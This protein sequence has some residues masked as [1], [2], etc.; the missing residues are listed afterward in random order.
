MSS[1][2]TERS[3]ANCSDQ[4]PGVQ[5][6]LQMLLRYRLSV[7]ALALLIAL[8]PIWLFW[9]CFALF[10]MAMEA[11][12]NFGQGAHGEIYLLPILFYLALMVTGCLALVVCAD[13]KLAISNKSIRFP[14]QFLF[15]LKF[16]LDRPWS[17]L[18]SL[19]FESIDCSFVQPSQP[20]ILPISA[21][22]SR[23]A[24]KIVL[25]FADGAAVTLAVKGLS[26][27]H[28][29]EFILAVQSFAP[30]AV[31]KQPLATVRLNFDRAVAAQSLHG[32]FTQLWEEELASRFGS[33]IFVPLEPG[34]VVEREGGSLKIEGQMSFGG[35]SAVYLVSR[36]AG[37]F[38][39]LKEA[40]LP[41]NT[42]YA[43]KQKA[44]EMFE[45]ESRLLSSLNHPRVA[46]VLDFF[47]AGDRNYILLEHIQGL[48]LRRFVS[49][50]GP[51]DPAVARRWFMEGAAILQYLHSQNPPVIHRDVTPDNLVL[52]RDG[53]LS[54]IDFGAA[55]ALVGTA[56][57]TVVGKQ[58][59]I[60]P[61]QF[62]GKASAASDIYSLAATIYFA[63]TGADP[64]PLSQLYPAL[65][66]P[67]TPAALNQLIAD[68]TRQD[69]SI[70]L[71]QL[72]DLIDR[73]SHSLGEG[74]E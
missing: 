67:N 34:Q 40:V 56:T 55:N 31:F 30:Q 2:L 14:W 16:C 49:Q 70:R 4:P 50:Q 51:Q 58:S 13:S 29:K 60:A 7:T 35:L 53:Q 41:L 54:L 64:E 12:S 15:D 66:A 21:E 42:D 25:R 33:T 18:Q 8:S 72:D 73:A 17:T 26:R 23:Q 68:C 37:T 48:D 52:A 3:G 38:F 32:S 65:L 71:S 39:I 36:A 45:R 5:S 43:L 57:G 22:Q 59:Y 44:L 28:L 24:D 61:E 69:S 20:E 9:S 19:D 1:L 10:S 46:R 63:L 62:R 11:W 74:N 47:V 6:Q 27:A